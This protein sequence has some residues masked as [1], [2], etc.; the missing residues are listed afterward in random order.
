MNTQSTESL[1]KIRQQFESSPYP[2]IPLEKSPK[3]DKNF[4]QLYLHSLVTP[5]YLRNQQVIEPEG[6]VILDAGCGSGYKSLVLAEANPGA[7]IVGI[8]LSEQSV[9]LAE[10]RLR[11]HGFEDNVEFH[12]LLI[13]DL[14]KLGLE[15]DYINCDEVLYL[16]PDI[17]AGL[18]SLKSVLKPTGIIR[19][20]L[21]NRL[22]RQ[23]FFR[24]QEAFRLMGLTEE[25]PGEMEVG[26]VVET[27]KALHDVVELKTKTWNP[28]Y[29]EE[30]HTETILMNFLLQ[31]D[32]GY[33]V[34][35]LFEALESTDLEFLSMTNW[36][37][38]ELTDLFKDP[39]DLPAF[40]AFS[41]PGVPVEEQLHLFNLLHPVH[42]LIDFWC[43]HPNQAVS[44]RSIAEWEDKD[45]QNARI[46]LHPQLKR[47]EVKEKINDCLS[48]QQPFEISEYISVPVAKPIYIDSYFAACCL[49]PLWERP[50]PV[51]ELVN[52]W[53]Q[54]RPYDPITLKPISEAESF[55]Q[56]KEFMSRLE[57]FLYVLL[58]RVQ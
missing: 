43:G 30:K 1:E 27:M 48:K 11:H 49:L 45:W 35:D 12:A 17:A 33:G 28:V 38:W 39:D 31:S 15:F 54:V 29:S 19:S 9:K 7:R 22:Q 18:R 20:N 21:H 46:H 40:L 58:E 16:L 13:E 5:F 4:N 26:L 8:D 36:R 32:K 41:L 2:R 14:P 55:E 6:K 37:H 53:L 51:V 50:Q 25:N 52:R 23:S 56:I 3:D 24:A 42:R 57:V 44:F 10:K 47:S 34:P